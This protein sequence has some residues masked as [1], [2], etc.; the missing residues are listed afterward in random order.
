LEGGQSLTTRRT[1][2]EPT[3]SP[4]GHGQANRSCRGR[5]LCA[6][7]G[8][9]EETRC[10]NHARHR[11]PPEIIAHAV[12]P[13]SRFALGYRDV[14]ELLAG[15][16]VT[17]PHETVRWRCRTFGQD[18]ANAPRRRRPRP[19]DKWHLEV[20]MPIKGAQRFPWRAVDQDRAV[21]AAQGES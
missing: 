17:V 3:W 5:R 19:G 15:R 6:T 18:Y 8:T 10:P 16:G 12:W 13:Y 7:P 14:E 4:C 20:S 21:L 11:F 9:K 1:A 2:T